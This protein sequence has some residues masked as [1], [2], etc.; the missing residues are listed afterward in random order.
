MARHSAEPREC[1]L[2]FRCTDREH[3]R[4]IRAAEEAGLSFSDFAREEPA[5]AHHANAAPSPPHL[6]GNAARL[7]NPMF[8]IA[9]LCFNASIN[10]Y[11]LPL[12]L[13]ASPFTASLSFPYLVTM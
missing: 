9:P 13:D 6:V 11:D 1:R 7:H 10:R 2:I 3:Q 8:P 12:L 4:L 5:C